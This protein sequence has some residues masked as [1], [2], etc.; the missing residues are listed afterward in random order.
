MRARLGRWWVAILVVG[1]GGD[2]GGD[3]GAG[4]AS[5]TGD[6]ATAAD[7]GTG[8]T[9]GPASNSGTATDDGT[10]DDTTGGS[11]TGGTDTA[12]IP[13]D[14]RI[15]WSFAGVPGGIPERE[16]ICAT[17]EWSADELDYAPIIQAAIDAC[18]S[19][20][21]VLLGPGSYPVRAPIVLDGSPQSITVRGAGPDQTLLV[22]AEGTV[23]VLGVD[24][25][26]PLDVAIVGGATK[27][28]TRIELASVPE[29][30]VAD[31]PIVIDRA[32][33]EELVHS[34]TDP[35]ARRMSQVAM[36]VA[37]EGNEIVLDVPL[38]FDFSVEPHLTSFA[39]FARFHGIE[40][41][42]L[43][44]AGS[45]SGRSFFFDGC[46]GCWLRNIA[47]HM[48]P[49][50]HLVG[51]N[52]LRCEIRDSVF[53]D[54][55]T[56]GPDNGGVVLYGNNTYW[57]VENNV[58]H[59]TFPSVELNY[60]SSA[61]VISYNYSTD[62]RA[63]VDWNMSACDFNDNHGP[64]NMMNLYEGN[65][66]VMFM[67]D[68]Y[69][70]SSS[71]GTLFRNHFGATHPT[72]PTGN[73]Q[74]VSLKRW[75]YYYNVVGNVLGDTDWPA[76]GEYQIDTEYGYEIAT[77]YQLGF[78]NIGNNSLTPGDGASPPGID[79][80][81]EETLLRHGNYDYDNMDTVW[82]PA[83]TEM[84][85]PGSLVYPSA[86]AWWPDATAWPPFGPDVDGLATE[87]PAETRA[88]DLGLP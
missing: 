87:L 43:E 72:Y 25:A 28:S 3:D 84:D 44:S 32:N 26:T 33:D 51:A 81:V 42:G 48:P 77:I 73:R 75:S 70:G 40:D 29:Q 31:T 60:S 15:D 65:R 47:S 19:E 62:V 57:K 46:Y 71:H 14:R 10:A 45:P 67:S 39:P 2:G 18:P 86:P 74:A 30:I 24:A 20:Q 54:S 68:A 36:V 59:R 85:L 82:D 5:D 80:H 55:Q 23:F 21:V 41:L 69:F 12:I 63:G 61:N 58:F 13:D 11:E 37:V 64:H 83:I 66:G 49:T 52:T 53:D 78:P 6:D 76:D 79:A 9:G 38:L 7:D 16:T 56:Y 50:Y 22:P 4:T 27:G 1:C 35:D 88:H 17:I 8:M 34:V